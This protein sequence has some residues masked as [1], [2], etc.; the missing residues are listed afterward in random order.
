M[1]FSDFDSPEKSVKKRITRKVVAKKKDK[2]D[3]G[4]L[5]V[6]PEQN[7]VMR[8]DSLASKYGFE[9]KEFSTKLGEE[10]SKSSEEG[11]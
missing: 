4:G 9:V 1:S 8:H 11:G 3:L 5:R 2:N 7:V 6:E 10:L